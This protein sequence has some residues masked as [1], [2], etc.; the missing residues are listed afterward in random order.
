MARDLEAF[1]KKQKEAEDNCIDSY[2]PLKKKPWIVG[3]RLKRKPSDYCKHLA[4]SETVYGEKLREKMYDTIPG[5]T[6]PSAEED[7]AKNE[8]FNQVAKGALQKD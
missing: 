8:L 6:K 7:N 5:L 2:Q 4:W 1:K 3:A